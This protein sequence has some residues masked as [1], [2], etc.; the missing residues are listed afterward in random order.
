M[1]ELPQYGIQL[2]PHFV[3]GMIPRRTQIQGQLGQG[4][5]PLDFRGEKIVD[6]VADTGVCAHRCSFSVGSDGIPGCCGDAANASP[7]IVWASSRMRR[8]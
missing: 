3:G 5:E 7:T 8:R 6:G 1:R 2:P 4:I